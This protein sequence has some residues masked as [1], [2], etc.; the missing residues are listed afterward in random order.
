MPAGRKYEQR[1]IRMYDQSDKEQVVLSARHMAA[2]VGFDEVNQVLIATAASELATNIAKYAVA[3]DVTLRII[4]CGEG[5]GIEIIA[6][7]EGPGI[8]DIEKAMED[9]F[10]T[11]RGSLGVGLPSVKRI[12]DEFTIESKPGHGTVVS[13]RKWNCNVKSGLPFSKTGAHPTRD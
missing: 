11:T 12:M 8:T 3:G 2:L 5:M 10:S 9:S 7:D 6:R 1:R 4:Q 13:A